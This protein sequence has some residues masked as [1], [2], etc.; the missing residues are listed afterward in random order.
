MCEANAFLMEQ[1]RE[2]KIL[3]NV[4]ELDIQEE[5][6]RIVNIFGEQKILKAKFKSYSAAERK[7]LLEP[8]R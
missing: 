5:E 2:E 6:I 7:I 4:D 1:G 3:D 8:L